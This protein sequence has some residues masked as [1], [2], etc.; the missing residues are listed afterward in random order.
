MLLLFSS[1]IQ[2][3]F[4]FISLCFVLTFVVLRID[5]WRVLC[6]GLFN[7]FSDD[8]CAFFLLFLSLFG[9][10]FVPL[11]FLF[12]VGCCRKNGTF[13]A[14]RHMCMCIIIDIIYKVKY[15]IL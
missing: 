7:A 14:K 10:L 6:G 12:F 2:M 3:E 15:S 13:G 9:L 11:C 1:S 8:F 4:G 5:L